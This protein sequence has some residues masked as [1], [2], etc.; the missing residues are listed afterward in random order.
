MS[1]GFK[2]HCAVIIQALK[3][4]VYIYH[5][6]FGFRWQYAQNDHD[7]DISVL[8]PATSLSVVLSVWVYVCVGVMCSHWNVVKHIWVFD[9][10]VASALS[11]QMDYD[12][13]VFHSTTFYLSVN[14]CLTTSIC[15]FTKQIHGNYR[16]L[17]LP[18]QNFYQ[19]QLYET[20]TACTLF[21]FL[22]VYTQGA[23]QNNRNT[24]QCGAVHA[25]AVLSHPNLH[26]WL[27]VSG[28]S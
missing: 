21:L 10:Q 11:I 28:L 26:K 24:S 2:C 15:P 6:H 9:E 22:C 5:T 25:V 4:C 14:F 19:V 27:L 23:G 16:P 12:A 18:R 1:N 7:V 8:A 17:P 13:F 20:S 3:P